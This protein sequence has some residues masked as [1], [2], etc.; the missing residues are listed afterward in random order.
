MTEEKWIERPYGRKMIISED[1]KTSHQ[2]ILIDPGKNTATGQKPELVDKFG[3]VG[4]PGIFYE[5]IEHQGF[6]DGSE[7]LEPSLKYV[8]RGLKSEDPLTF[9]F[10]KGSAFYSVQSDESKFGYWHVLSNESRK[11]IQ[12]K[13][14]VVKI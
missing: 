8:A 13:L 3:L 1:G 2:I 6:L 12:L 10:A 14:R 7:S 9:F 5:H 4:H 11:T